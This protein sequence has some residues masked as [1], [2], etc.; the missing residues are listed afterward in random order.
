MV[1]WYLNALF[2][3]DQIYLPNTGFVRRGGGR[4]SRKQGPRFA[5]MRPTAIAAGRRKRESETLMQVKEA[6]L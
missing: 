6:D 5:G 1:F 2:D 3:P 4:M